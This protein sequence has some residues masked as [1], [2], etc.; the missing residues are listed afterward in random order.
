MR[1]W[2]DELEVKSVQW[3]S[4]MVS[5]RPPTVRSMYDISSCIAHP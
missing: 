4:A 1:H 5:R 3:G 2:Q